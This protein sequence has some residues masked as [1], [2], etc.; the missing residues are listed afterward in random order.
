MRWLDGWALWRAWDSPYS[1]N[2]SL[3][4]QSQPE[5]IAD[6]RVDRTVKIL[7]FIKPRTKEFHYSSKARVP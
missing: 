4:N 1:I 6:A 7:P 5:V 3:R 2:V